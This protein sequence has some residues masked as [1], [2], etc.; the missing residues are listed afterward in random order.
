L[1]LEVAKHAGRWGDRDVAS[2]D[3]LRVARSTAKLLAS[4]HFGEVGR[5]IEQNVPI[6]FL[7]EEKPLLVTA[8]AARV[9]NLR[10]GVGPIGAGEV[11]RHHGQGFVF[12][13][14]LRGETRRDV[15]IDAGHFAV[16]RRAPGLEVRLHDVTAAAK[17]GCGA[18][19]RGYRDHHEP[20]GYEERRNESDRPET[21]VASGS[22]GV[23]GLG[24]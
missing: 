22:F 16:C 20:D 19:L 18:Q 4:P 17:G 15:A 10:P 13:P 8:K 5:V 11:T 14:K 24:H 12:L 9:V 7:P 1:P 2:L 3:D 6:H 23:A 21:P